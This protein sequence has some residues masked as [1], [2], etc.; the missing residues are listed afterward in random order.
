MSETKEPESVITTVKLTKKGQPDKRQ[1]TCRA[2]LQKANSVIKQAIDEIKSKKKRDIVYISSSEDEDENND[3]D[4]SEPEY[5]LEVIKKKDKK[6]PES[7][8]QPV[9]V[10]NVNTDLELK[11]NETMVQFNKQLDDIKK[12]NTN[13]KNTLNRTFHRQI[14]AMNQEMLLKF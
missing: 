4:I 12:E 1:Q 8:S 9:P 5:E 3:Q 13:L 2:N 10:N 11:F 14:G 6:A 7:Q